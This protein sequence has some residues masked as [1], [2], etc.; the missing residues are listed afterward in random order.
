MTTAR[1]GAYDVLNR[2]EEGAYANL[3]LDQYLDEAGDSLDPRDRAFMTELVYGTVKYRLKLDWAIDHMLTGVGQLRAGPRILLRTAFYQLFHMDRVPPRAVVNETVNLAK[4]RFHSGVAALANGVLRNYLR[5]PE[6]VSWPD[7]EDPAKYLS[8]M[9]SH[10]QWMLERWIR[11]YGEE[12]AR[13]LCEFNNKPAE[14]W[15]RAN[16]LRCEP[17]ELLRRLES[18]GC[19]AAVSEVLPEALELKLGPPIP[20]LGS[21]RDGWFAVQDLTSMLAA[22]ALAPKPGDRVLD[23]CA[24]PGGKTGHLAQLMENRGGILAMDVHPHRVR[25]IQSAMARLGVTCVESRTGDGTLISPG[26]QGIFD[27]ILLDAPCSG[28]GV[29][30]RRADARWRKKERDIQALAG[31]QRKLFHRAVDCLK[32]GGRLIYSTCTLEPEENIRL[33]ESVCRERADMEMFLEPVQYLPF[34]DGMEGFF[35]AGVRRV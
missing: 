21:Y 4:R 24:A 22:R 19:G 5:R 35:L 28:L 27:G 15:I 6:Q 31:L 29:L 17:G 9:Y 13:S 32:P 3:A 8:V 30:R 18:E 16:T 25:L 11:R 26:E 14:L 34:R 7:R 1:D 23:V 12:D 33:V 2:I 10:P 20:R